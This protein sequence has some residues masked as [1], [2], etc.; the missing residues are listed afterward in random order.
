MGKLEAPVINATT[1]D[2]IIGE[3]GKNL[4]MPAPAQPKNLNKWATL[5]PS[6]FAQNTVNP[7]RSFVE[8]LSI[9]P[10]PKL[11]PIKLNLGDPTL[12][13]NLPPPKSAIEGVQEAL[14]SGKYDGYG[15]SVGFP[16]SRQAVV[17]AFNHPE[18]PIT[19]DDVILTSGCSHALQIAI[20]GIANRGDNILVPNPGFPLYTTLMRP[21]GI[22]DRAYNLILGGKEK[23]DYDHMESLIDKRTQAIIINNPSNPIGIVLDESDLKKILEIAYKHKVVIIADEIYGDLTFN[24]AAF[25]NIATL[26]PKVPVI[27]CDGI[28]K[29]YMVPGWRLGWIIIHDRF[30][31]LEN[32]RKGMISL[33]QK[34]VGPCALM[35]GALPKILKE[36]PQSYF[37]ESRKII[38]LNAKLFFNAFS[39]IPG[40]KPIMS[41]GAMYMMV[42]I[43]P[44]IYG[45]DMQFLKDMIKEQSVYCLPGGAFGT[46]YWFRVV[47]TYPESLSIEAIKRIAEFCQKRRSNH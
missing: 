10:N 26:T 19:I 23:I 21:L 14:L 4:P 28:A 8:A 22:E 31:V 35:Q 34:I 47:L 30:S 27:S 39:E 36:T 29:R 37:E 25:K 12:I 33:T 16:Q 13:G 7:V 15:P 45:D 9:Q 40:L 20:E 32:V 46:P 24:G 17:D 1:C 11:T 41:N 42:K 3:N 6:V 2:K 43:D 5:K 44:K 38:E 18:A